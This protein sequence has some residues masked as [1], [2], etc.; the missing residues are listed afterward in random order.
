M[1]R[2]EMTYR[3]RPGP[4]GRWGGRWGG[5][6]PRGEPELGPI[7]YGR[8]F[9]R[10]YDRDLGRGY[11]SGVGWGFAREY[12][13]RYARGFGGR[14]GG[15][16]GRYGRGYGGGYGGYGRDYGRSAA[17]WGIA[18]RG[19]GKPARGY[20]V[21]G[22]HTY[23]LDYGSISG[24]PTTDYSGRAGYPTGPEETPRGPY[25]PRLEEVGPEGRGR[26]LYGSAAGEYRGRGYGSARR[27]RGPR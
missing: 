17:G 5:R 6:R 12:G 8:E 21:R 1:A 11:G 16:Y 9:G 18:T 27:Y 2:Y 4:R 13:G 23:D 14:Y 7:G 19:I 20:P 25:T 3:E 22:I 24:G 15:E 26:G 10:G